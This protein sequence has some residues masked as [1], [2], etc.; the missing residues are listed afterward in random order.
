M[1]ELPEVKNKEGFFSGHFRQKYKDENIRE[2]LIGKYHGKDIKILM[3]SDNLYKLLKY[4]I[5][6][7]RELINNTQITELKIKYL[8]KFR[9]KYG[10]RLTSIVCKGTYSHNNTVLLDYIK[11]K[12]T[13]AFA[14]FK[15]GLDE[16]YKTQLT[17]FVVFER[18]YQMY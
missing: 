9:N 2:Y 12:Y 11:T 17:H 8:D 1:N 16:L 4:D 10:F 15:D 13:E 6:T 3:V 7:T 18:T 5:D 14:P